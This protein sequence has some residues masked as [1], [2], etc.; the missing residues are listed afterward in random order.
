MSSAV[1]EAVRSVG[2]ISRL[3]KQALTLTEAAA[4]R[5]KALLANK[6]E[7]YIRLGVR[8]RGCNGLSYTMNY[9]ELPAK[10][11]E[12]V[13]QHGARVLID[14]GVL[15]HVVGTTMDFHTDRLRSEFVFI[16]PNAKGSCGC[17]ESFNV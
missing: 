10:F 2:R 14:P 5:V 11:D 4:D 6:K 3:N 1:K 8:K 17:G 12:V 16:N 13:E 15:M 9:A 7:E